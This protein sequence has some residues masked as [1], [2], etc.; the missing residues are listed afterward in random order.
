MRFMRRAPT[1]RVLPSPEI[2]IEEPY[3]GAVAAVNAVL[4]LPNSLRGGKIRLTSL[5][6]TGVLVQSTL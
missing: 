6:S 3:S 5:T 4:V 1:A 2:L